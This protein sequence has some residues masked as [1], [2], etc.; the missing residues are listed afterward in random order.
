MSSPS[1]DQQKVP[2]KIE[3]PDLAK[4]KHKST[5]LNL[6]LIYIIFF[7]ISVSHLIA[8]E[9]FTLKFFVV[10]LKF[11]F[12]WKSCTF[13]DNPFLQ[14][15]G[16]FYSWS[17]TSFLQ[18]EAATPKWQVCIYVNTLVTLDSQL[19]EI[20]THQ[21]LLSLFPIKDWRTTKII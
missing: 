14:P 8:Q 10:Y 1:I 9:I 13:S 2:L 11:K 3:L 20:K 17:N 21:T 4:K 19:K 15:Y 18:I 7:S 5:Q 16:C 12:N 6:H